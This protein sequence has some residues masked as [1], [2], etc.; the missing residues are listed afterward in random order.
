MFPATYFTTQLHPVPTADANF[1][2][3][4]TDFLFL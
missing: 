3:I 4:D 2:Q 1:A